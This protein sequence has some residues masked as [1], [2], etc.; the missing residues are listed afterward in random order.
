MSLSLFKWGS[1]NSICHESWHSLHCIKPNTNIYAEVIPDQDTHYIAVSSPIF[2]ST[3]WILF[4]TLSL[5]LF[6]IRIATGMKLYH[7]CYFNGS[8]LWIPSEEICTIKCT[9]QMYNLEAV[10]FLRWTFR[11]CSNKVF[12]CECLRLSFVRFRHKFWMR[13]IT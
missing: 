2:Y 4:Q 12:S 10:H 9:C 13:P 7:Q 5:P 1:C 6:T 11:F 3:N 8:Q